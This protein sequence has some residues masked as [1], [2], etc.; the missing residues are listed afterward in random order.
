MIIRGGAY[1]SDRDKLTTRYR[2]A[3][4]AHETFASPR[5]VMPIGFRCAKD[6]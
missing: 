1:N 6:L 2:W 5:Y 4:P 3:A